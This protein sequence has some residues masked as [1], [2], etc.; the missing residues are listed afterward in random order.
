M[1]RMLAIAARSLLANAIGLILAMVLL[2]GFI[3][4]PNGLCH[5]RGFVYTGRCNCRTDFDKDFAKEFAGPCR[6]RGFGDDFCRVVSDV[7]LAGGNEYRWDG[8]FVPGDFYCLV[9]CIDRRDCSVE[10]PTGEVPAKQETLTVP[11]IANAP[12]C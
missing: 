8:Q 5:R 2:T 11:D 10:I 9:G 7:D 6:R 4:R 1:T 3:N 12:H